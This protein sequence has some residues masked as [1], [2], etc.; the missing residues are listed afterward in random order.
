MNKRLYRRMMRNH[1]RALRTMLA[2]SP[3]APERQAAQKY[4]DDYPIEKII[5]LARLA[6]KPAESFALVGHRKDHQP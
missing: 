6:D 1:E 3:N 2:T 4:L 5:Q